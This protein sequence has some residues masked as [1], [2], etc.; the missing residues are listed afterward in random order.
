[1]N[2]NDESAVMILQD[3]GIHVMAMTLMHCPE[4]SRF[5]NILSG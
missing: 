2:N 1:M 5:P 4:N 3:Y